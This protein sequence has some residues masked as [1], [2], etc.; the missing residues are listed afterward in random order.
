M[1]ALEKSLSK[2]VALSDVPDKQRHGMADDCEC[3][4]GSF[5]PS[6]ISQSR[7]RERERKREKVRRKSHG[8]SSGPGTCP[9]RATW[10]SQACTKRERE[11]QRKEITEGPEDEDEA[12]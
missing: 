11:S 8:D 7:E 10:A 2:L 6:F 5:F 4:F 9:A 1:C 12:E 3:V